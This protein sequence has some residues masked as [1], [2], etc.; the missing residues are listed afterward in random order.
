[1]SSWILQSLSQMLRWDRLI[2][3]AN[4]PCGSPQGGREHAGC[5][6]KMVAAVPCRRQG[7]QANRGYSRRARDD[8][9]PTEEAEQRGVH[10]GSPSVHVP[11]FDNVDWQP[12][13]P[14]K[15]KEPWTAASEGSGFQTAGPDG[16]IPAARLTDEDIGSHKAMMQLFSHG[17]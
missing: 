15:S 12:E 14:Q 8:P 6:C 10:S 3:I 5:C 2:K 7:Q 13:P 16:R 9:Q 11:H 17:V 1:M 4:Q